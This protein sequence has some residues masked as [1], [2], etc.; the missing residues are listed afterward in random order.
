MKMEDMEKVR[1]EKRNRKGAFK[2]KVFLKTV[3]EN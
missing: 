2:N 3:E 1:I